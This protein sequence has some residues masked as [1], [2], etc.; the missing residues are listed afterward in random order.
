M[1][2]AVK[3]IMKDEKGKVMVLVMCL[4]LVGGLIIAPLLGLMTTGLI[5]GQVYEKKTAELYAADAGVEDA[6]WKINNKVDGLPGPCQNQSWSYNIS[7]VN[8]KSVDV[9]IE[10]VEGLTYRVESSATGD[11]S[12]TEIEAYI[13]NTPIYDDYSGIGNNVIT[14][15]CN[16]TLQGPSEVDPPEGDEHGPVG[17]Y[18]GDWPTAE[19]LSDIYWEDVKDEDPYYSSI[20]DVIDYPAGFG[21]LYR[22]GTLQ[23]YNT[24]TAGFNTSLN[25]T[26]YITGETLLGM[27]N[28]DFTLDLNEQTI[29]VE[30]ATGAA[31]EDDP[32][33]PAE[34]QYAL[35]IG[36]K[37]TLTGSGCVIA[38][39]SIEFKPN[40]ACSPTDHIF[41]LSIRGE[42]HMQPNGDFY[43]TL[44]GLAEVYIQN[45]DATWTD[46][47]GFE[48]NFPTL[49]EVGQISGISTWEINPQ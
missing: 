42:T 32:C 46:P 21:P 16:Y 13:T 24:G 36:T 7:D 37:C 25:G 14:S 45:G 48:L 35:R 2:A 33:N 12:E 10:W 43:G 11:G 49:A 26:V 29:F 22:D 38:V 17:N 39:G 34:N 18:T 5:A 1:K 9:T 8:G 23:I 19:V 30:D 15:P 47:S 41:V 44:A 3:S 27:T 40:L 4:L 6:I 28:Q 31:P 20:L